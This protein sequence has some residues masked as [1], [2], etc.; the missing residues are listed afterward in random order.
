M[1]LFGAWAKF[2]GS[3]QVLQPRLRTSRAPQPG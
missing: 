3:T 2:S 1:K